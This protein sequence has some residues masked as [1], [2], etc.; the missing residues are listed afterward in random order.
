[1]WR[2]RT[3]VVLL[4]IAVPVVLVAAIV[5]VL[6]GLD[7]VHQDGRWSAVNRSC[8]TLDGGIAATLGMAP[9]PLADDGSRGAHDTAELRNCFYAGGRDSNDAL[10]VTVSL[11]RGGVLETSHEAAVAAVDDNPPAGFRALGG[12]APDHRF[13]DR[14]PGSGRL[15]L[16]TVVDNAQVRVQLDDRALTGDPEALR[17]PLQKVA[18]QAIGNL[19][20]GERPHAGRRLDVH[21]GGVRPPAAG[22]EGLAG[23]DALVR[24]AVQQHRPG[25]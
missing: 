20:D 6:M 18:D 19:G 7:A 16:I 1:M 17:A 25:A 5:A 3:G 12:K 9:Q 15:V 11:H 4:L 14:G 10:Q 24:Y 23:G 22:G 13:G 21:A 8:P 2:G